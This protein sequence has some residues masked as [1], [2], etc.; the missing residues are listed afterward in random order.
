[1][2]RPLILCSLAWVLL[3]VPAAVV[4]AEDEGPEGGIERA[5]D[6]VLE[7]A[8]SDDPEALKH[9]AAM[10]A[11][12]PWR[13]VDVLIARGRL[14]AAEAFAR[15][16]PGV[17]AEAMKG[18]VARRRGKPDDVASRTAFAA[19]TAAFGAG[20]RQ[21]ARAAL[22]GVT[23]DAETVIGVYVLSLQA[24]ERRDGEGDTASYEA[25]KSAAAAAR[26]IGWLG[27]A[28]RILHAGAYHA[29]R[30]GYHAFALECYRAVLE[31]NEMRGDA[32]NVTRTHHNLGNVLAALGQPGEAIAE[33]QRALSWE[34]ARGDQRAVAGTLIDLGSLHREMGAFVQ[35]R[36]HY[37]RGLA[38]AEAV[39][40]EPWVA[41][42]LEGMGL[43][44]S[45]LGDEKR[46]REHWT[47]CLS[48]RERLGDKQAVASAEQNLGMA[49]V[50]LGEPEQALEHLQRALALRTS[51]GDRVGVAQT[52]SAL[53]QLH[54]EQGQ[55]DQAVVRWQQALQLRLLLG[56]ERGA[57]Q[58]RVEMALL[59]VERERYPE[60]ITSLEGLAP[61]VAALRDA[62]LRV[63]LLTGL[64][65]ARAASGDAKGAQEL[66]KR[67]IGEILP[68]LPGT[69]PA[70]GRP[71]TLFEVGF[72]AA[73]E[74]MD[75]E[76]ALWFL[77]AGRAGDL[78][79]RMA[80]RAA[81]RA[82]VVPEALRRE[83]AQARVEVAEAD[84][85]WR[86]AEREKQLRHMRASRRALE[87]ARERLRAAVLAIDGHA[88][89]AAG[90]FA[91]R[92]APLPDI[93]GALQ[94][95]E[96][97]VSFGRHGDAYVAVV[98]THETVAMRPV[99]A[100]GG[101]RALLGSLADGP[102]GAE[103]LVALRAGLVTPLAL[104]A[105][106]TQVLVAPE[107][108]LWRVPFGALFDVPV[109]FVPSGS[110]LV[111]LCA[112]AAA[113]GEGVLALADAATGRPH[114]PALPGTR[115]EAQAVG[116]VVLVGAEA[117]RARLDETLGSRSRWRALHIA[118]Y[119]EVDGVQPL[120]SCI[121]LTPGPGD[122]GRLT[123]LDLLRMQVPADL[124]VLSACRTAT[125]RLLAGEAP[126]GLARSFLGAGAR[127]VLG[128]LWSADDEATRALMAAFYERW[129]PAKGDAVGAAAALRAAQAHVRAQ[130][131]W[132]DPA[133]WAGWVLWGLPD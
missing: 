87:A 11:P 117:S 77:E 30:Y 40:Y 84:R 128:T 48:I 70:V 85:A 46:A 73:L 52:S 80:M 91:P 113:R 6:A 108:D 64:S 122:D 132:S 94:A 90:L 55:Y 15:A 124:V 74:R 24:L 41:N 104:P 43:L 123:C 61:Q 1:M 54:G 125:G 93:R 75:A 3:L 21:G 13:V 88:A 81:R 20:D 4:L 26:K 98:V 18:Y 33:Y 101:L 72:A 29:Y 127:Q 89:R 78:Y 28:A 83:E 12:D 59:D 60:A 69:G 16:V 49:A 71:P 131:K 97:L 103:G 53:A 68:G 39:G 10:N 121:A 44:E 23:P 86:A 109:V 37:A 96:A 112:Q 115:L 31:L 2:R 65:R 62:P 14:D 47:R 19:W 17:E 8:A 67:A 120:Q 99:G 102:P 51:V 36:D 38:A 130:E 5:A 82:A 9:R 110:M 32:E 119:A 92:P 56:D 133:F 66:A 107:G 58:I 106:V 129:N 76:E 7:A 35:A 57:L 111:F 95:G 100:D 126:L 25:S 79:A 50:R 27:H 22:A 34:Q 118:C 63:R 45:A 42:A 116:D 114:M 105:S